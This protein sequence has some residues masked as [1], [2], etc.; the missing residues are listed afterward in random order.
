MRGFMVPLWMAVAL[1]AGPDARAQSVRA[2]AP[3]T[4]TPDAAQ[5]DEASA[6]L[7]VVERFFE[8]ME[9][10]DIET[11]AEL[12]VPEGTTFS[13]RIGPDGPGPVR[14]RSLQALIDA[15]AESDRLWQERIW[16]PTVLVHGPV[17]VVWAPYDFHLDGAF[18]HCGVDAFTL[19]R[20]DG[21]WKLA[22]AAWTAE[23]EGCEPS[24]LGPVAP[25]R[26]RR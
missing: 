21:E 20:I 26:G 9:A 3:D 16:D 2:E 10:R 25:P 4:P 19:F 13:Q 18:S 15:L 14:I 17:A 24:P 7:A 8:A 22:G 12:Q 6:V 11:F 5:E 23:T 1:A